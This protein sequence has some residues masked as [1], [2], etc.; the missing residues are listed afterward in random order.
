MKFWALVSIF[1]NN[2]F[3]RC[4]KDL[5]TLFLTP[6]VQHFLNST[7]MRELHSDKVIY[8]PGTLRMV[9]ALYSE[10]LLI[11][12][13]EMWTPWYSGHLWSPH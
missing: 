11:R 1:F 2:M 7:P 10:F 9:G 13:P 4:G 12:T 8:Q 3:S 5:E 6:T